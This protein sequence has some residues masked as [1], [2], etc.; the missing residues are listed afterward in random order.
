EIDFV[1]L[2]GRSEIVAQV[3][4]QIQT[5]LD[6]YGAGIQVTAV[7]LQ[8]AQ[9]PEEVQHAFE[10]AIK[11]REDKQRYIREAEAYTNDIVPK[12]RGAAARRIQ[13]A[14][15]YRA[16]V[17]EEA[18]GES[19]RFEKLL[20]EY[21]RAPEITRKRLYIESIENVLTNTETVLLDI[22]KG[23]N[24]VYL[25]LDKM[26]SRASQAA[27]ASA[28]S[29]STPYVSSESSESNAKNTRG[30]TRSRDGRGR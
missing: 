18:K 8:D 30:S 7:N 2:E 29:D 5:I 4:E 1:L 22:K 17:I 3:R 15:A 23:N 21:T 14:E 27:P 11:A 24:L 13:D 9:P 10:D 16:K 12:A 28:Q 26:T 20:V 6:A 19:A 25:P